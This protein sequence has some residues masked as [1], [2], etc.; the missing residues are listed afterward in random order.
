M[1][2]TKDDVVKMLK[3]GLCE[4][5][6]TKSDGTTRNMK[7]TLHDKILT[8][9]VDEINKHNEKLLQEGKEVKPKKENPNLVSVVDTEVNGWRSFKIDSI[10]TIN[11]IEEII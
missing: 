1:T 9:Y 2:Y 3:L 4:V 5:V 6:F 10:Q 8:P 7:C 11:L